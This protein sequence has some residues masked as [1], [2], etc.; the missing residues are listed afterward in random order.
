MRMV[1]SALTMSVLFASS[2]AHADEA[3]FAAADTNGDGAISLAEVMAAYP[4]TAGD[5]FEES[6]VNGSGSLELEEFAEAL[7]SGMLSK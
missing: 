4:A 3:A 2:I 6:D 1:A 5:R 7:E